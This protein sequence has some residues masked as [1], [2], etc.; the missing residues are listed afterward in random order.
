MGN[1]GIALAR[2]AIAAFVAGSVLVY[3]T[4]LRTLRPTRFDDAYMFLRYAKHA[5]AGAG[6]S[7]NVGEGP[8]YGATSTLFLFIVTAIRGLTHLPDAAVLMAP[9]LAAAWAACAALVALGFMVIDTGALRQAW[10]PL[11]VVPGLLLSSQFRYHSLSGMETTVALLCNSLLALSVVGWCRR[12]S[13]WRFAA[14]LG[15]SYA[16]FLARP[17]NG[18]YALCFPPMFLAA[19]DRRFRRAAVVFSLCFLG[20]LLIDLGIKNALFGDMLPLPFFAKRAGFYA[21][22]LGVQQWN[23]VGFGLDFL[24]EAAPWLIALAWCVHARTAPRLLAVLAPVAATFAYLLSVNQVMGYGARYFYPSLPYVMLAAFVA[25]K[26]RVSHCEISQPFQS[27]DRTSGIALKAL[28]VVLFLLLTRTSPLGRFAIRLWD[29]HAIGQPTRFDA[30]TRYVVAATSPLPSAD[31]WP[32]IVRMTA[33]AQRLPPGTIVAASES[34][35]LGATVPDQ[36]VVDMVG[37]H[38]RHVAR[39][40]FSTGY[41]MTKQ[42]DVLWLPHPD[43]SFIVADILDNTDFQQGYDYYPGAFNYGLAIRK[44]S[45]RYPAIKGTLEAEFAV[46]YPGRMLEDFRGTPRAQ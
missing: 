26:D 27:G 10:V 18:L 13:R 14:M 33:F 11:L 12:P 41:L 43:Y 9:S 23:A 39:T 25:L 44:R 3:A 38:D 34:G 32:N 7:W 5:I 35:L 31:W 8:A 28:T 37:L 4:T 21:G 36:Q 6:F 17:D 1:R 29:E 15:A 30:H 40:G 16:A 22:Y 46:V 20:V 2:G 19:S 24:Q 42:P 45:P